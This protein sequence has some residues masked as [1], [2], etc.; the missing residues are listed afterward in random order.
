MLKVIGFNGSPRKGYNTDQMVRKALE[1]A[2]ENG[3][4]T[5]FY[6]LIDLKFQPCHSCY[7]C[8]K[9]PKYTGKCAIK[10]DLT[11]II[12]EIKTADVLIFGTPIYYGFPSA[13]LHSALERLWFSSYRY[14][15]EATSFPKITK[16]GMIYT[17]NVTEEFAKK[18]GYQNMFNQITRFNQMIFK[19]K[20]ETLCAFDTQ[21]IDDFSK[22]EIETFDR[23]HKIKRHKEHWQIDLQNA[24]NL[25]KS[26]VTNQK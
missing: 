19:G 22:Y 23:V 16:T 2:K 10:D 4:L 20:C 11:P 17:M 15:K 1:G 18:I 9:G 7:Y 13:L 3:A 6:Q 26:L 5:K 24:Y 12:E 25:G 8:K 14:T 21:Q